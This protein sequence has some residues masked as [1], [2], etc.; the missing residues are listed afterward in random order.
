MSCVT[1]SSI[2]FF[3]ALSWL[4]M[5]CTTYSFFTLP[6][7]INRMIRFVKYSST[8]YLICTI[9]FYCIF[10]LVPFAGSL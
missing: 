4:R 9:E 10:A 7:S 1:T 3:T 6:I 5:V 2:Y 8:N